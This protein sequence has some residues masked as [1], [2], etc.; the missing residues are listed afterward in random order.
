MDFASIPLC[1]SASHQLCQGTAGVRLEIIR[2]STAATR[3]DGQREQRREGHSH[4]ANPAPTSPERSAPVMPS[5]R[6]S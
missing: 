4:S 1:L 2:G 5:L 3:R 6:M